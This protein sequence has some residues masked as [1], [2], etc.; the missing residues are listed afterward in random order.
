MLK[1]IDIFVV[2]ETNLDE[3][4]FGIFFDDGFSKPSRLDRSKNGRGI[5][6]VIRNTISITILEKYIFPI[7]VESIFVELNFRKCKWLLCGT[8]HSPSQSDDYFF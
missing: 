1:Y 6:I 8:Y 7:D 3:T 5:M 2:T 4:F